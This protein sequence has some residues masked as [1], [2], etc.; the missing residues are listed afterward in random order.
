[1]D[2]LLMLWQAIPSVA[3]AIIKVAGAVAV[4]AALAKW[5]KDHI[6]PVLAGLKAMPALRDELAKINHT[7]L[8]AEAK[9]R[10]LADSDPNVATFECRADGSIDHVNATFARWL[11]VSKTDLVGWR[12]LSYVPEEDRDRVRTEFERA[13]NERRIARISFVFK[14]VSGRFV[15]VEASV[16]PV[17]DDGPVHQWVGAMRRIEPVTPR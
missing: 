3:Q 13:R 5:M 4:L 7:L 11:E 8:V 9:Q 1:M 12:W 6:T 2:E 16:T 17:P 15:F 14:T 10:A